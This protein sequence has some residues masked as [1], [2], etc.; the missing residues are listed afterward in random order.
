ME[1]VLACHEV[2]ERDLPG[3]RPEIAETESPD[4]HE[5]VV[6]DFESHRILCPG[7]ERSR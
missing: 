3:A 1:A 2:P 4:T 7:I 5:H 6:L